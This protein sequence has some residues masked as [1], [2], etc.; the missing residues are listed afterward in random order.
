MKTRRLLILALIFSAF[1]MNVMAVDPVKDTYSYPQRDGKYTFTSNW[2]YSRITETY[3]ITPV[4]QTTPPTPPN[5]LLS[6]SENGSM[7]STVRGAAF[8]NGKLLFSSRNLNADA[9]TI[10]A[11]IIM[12]AKTGVVEKTLVLNTPGFAAIQNPCNYITLDDANNVLVSNVK[13]VNTGILQ[14][15]KIDMETGNGTKI[16]E[17]GAGSYCAPDRIDAFGVLGDVNGTATIWATN[18]QVTTPASAGII[19]RWHVADGVVNQDEPDVIMMDMSAGFPILYG[20]SG[21]ATLAGGSATVFPIA[22]DLVYVDGAYIYPTLMQVTGSADDGFTAQAVDGFFELDNPSSGAVPSID[23]TTNPEKEFGMAYEHN[24]FVQFSIENDHFFGMPIRHHG[25]GTS[26]APQQSFRLFKYK[27]ENR[28]TREAEILW[29]FPEEGLAA[30]DAAHNGNDY[31]FAQVLADVQGKEANIYI[32][33]GGNGIGS[34]TLKVD[35]GNNIDLPNTS[36]ITIFGGKG[37]I[38]FSEAV[39]A[40]VF[41]ITGQLVAKSAGASIPVAQGIYVVK[42]IASNGEAAVKKVIVQ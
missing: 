1:C 2:L 7:A 32:Y 30:N 13:L 36:S 8:W 17:Q 31:F 6:Y 29:T 26:G 22:D 27:D 20:T 19:F 9:V 42:A 34:Y 15:W 16:L 33:S 41:S 28:I 14:I 38:K 4:P 21:P 40:Q 23:T 24:W 35:G 39:S 37:E 5:F 10:P 3:N 12:D 25:G 18:S 11:I